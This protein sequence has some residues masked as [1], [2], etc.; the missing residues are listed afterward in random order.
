MEAA[1]ITPVVKTVYLANGSYDDDAKHP[2]NRAEAQ[3]IL[4]QIKA[5]CEDPI[6][7]G[8]TI[9]VISLLN[10]SGQAKYIDAQLK[11]ERYISK[12]TAAERQ[13]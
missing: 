5:I 1:R 7:D 8:K 13:T 4:E 10:T 6:Y 3:A 12:A 2:V 11:S 9:G